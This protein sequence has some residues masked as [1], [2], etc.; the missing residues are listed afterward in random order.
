LSHLLA[1]HG[2]ASVG[3]LIG[4]ALPGPVTDF[5]ALPARKQVSALHAE[6]CTRCGN[7]TRCPYLAITLGG[8]GLPATEES[9]CIGCTF[10]VQNCFAGALHM[11]DRA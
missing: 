6:L 9:R 5:M 11:R 3:E 10:C 1:E 8:D 4:R 2:L 7:C